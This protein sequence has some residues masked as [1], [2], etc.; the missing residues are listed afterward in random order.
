MKI[1][2][3]IARKITVS[4]HMYVLAIPDDNQFYTFYLTHSQHL[5]T[6]KMFNGNAAQCLDDETLMHLAY[7]GFHTHK[8]DYLDLY[9]FLEG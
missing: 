2:N 8:E 5:A 9:G 7:E 6:L 3:I 1:E 4:P